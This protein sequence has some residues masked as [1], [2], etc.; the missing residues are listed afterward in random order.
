MRLNS[1]L[2]V[3]FVVGSIVDSKHSPQFEH[4]KPDHEPILASSQTLEE[5]QELS[6]VV[7]ELETDQTSPIGRS[8]HT[9]ISYSD[10]LYLWGGCD[11][12]LNCDTSFYQFDIKKELW[13]SIKTNGII[14]NGRYKHIAW[15]GQ[16]ENPFLWIFGGNTLNNNSEKEL[17]FL[18]S[19]QLFGLYLANMRWTN[20]IIRGI[21]PS[22]RYGM[23][24]T[25]ISST[26]SIMFGGSNQTHYHNDL[27]IFDSDK[28]EWKEVKI[29]S[30]KSPTARE[31]HT[32][33]LHKNKIIIFG[34]Y[35]NNEYLNDL[36]SF[37][38]KTN[39]WKSILISDNSFPK[40]GHLSF[41]LNNLMFVIGG[42][43]DILEKCDKG[44]SVFDIEKTEKFAKVKINSENIISKNTLIEN[45]IE[46]SS[47]IVIGLNVYLFGGCSNNFCFNSTWLIEFDKQP[48]LQ[49]NTL[50]NNNNKWEMLCTQDGWTNSNFVCQK[51]RCGV[52][53]SP[54]Y[55]IGFCNSDYFGDVCEFKCQDGYQPTTASKVL[56]QFCQGDG[57]WSPLVGECVAV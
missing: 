26:V 45:E 31:G 5:Y 54:K 2:L 38:I 7:G 10:S 42:C 24:M 8:G 4:L 35:N 18:P 41:V 25:T 30:G 57:K 33:V 6:F 13:K 16:S 21:S 9:L 23:T 39:E 44:I 52:L 29:S 56:S 51:V 40:A 34:G 48:Q 27:F 53:N 37:D 17:N 15:I 36:H 20:P 14:P 3:L 47:S 12:D 46:G 22:S 50:N 1:F 19:N 49:Y 55:T 43:N 28:L 32:A 11:L